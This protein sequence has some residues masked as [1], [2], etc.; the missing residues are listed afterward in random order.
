MSTVAKLLKNFLLSSGPNK[1]GCLISIPKGLYRSMKAG[2]V[3]EHEGIQV[4]FPL[5]GGVTDEWG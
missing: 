5:Y 2:G 3:D 4:G 1:V